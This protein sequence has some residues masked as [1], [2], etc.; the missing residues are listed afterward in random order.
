[1]TPEPLDGSAVPANMAIVCGDCCSVKT[2]P[3]VAP[4]PGV[5]VRVVTTFVVP[6]FTLAPVAA[7]PVSVISPPTDAAL[8]EAVLPP[9][10]ETVAPGVLVALELV[11]APPAI[12]T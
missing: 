9:V 7:P 1:M 11:H 8:V 4:A 5:A 6:G 2:G 3:S 12:V 10:I